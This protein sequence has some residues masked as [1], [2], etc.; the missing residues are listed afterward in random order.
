MAMQRRKG[1]LFLLGIPEN[2]RGR[3]G[4]VVGDSEGIFDCQRMNLRTKQNDRDLICSTE[5][6][7]I[8]RPAIISTLGE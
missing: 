4:G 2:G 6:E 5:R 1:S 3:G 8:A 7:E